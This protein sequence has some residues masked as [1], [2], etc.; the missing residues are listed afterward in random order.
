MTEREAIENHLFYQEPDPRRNVYYFSSLIGAIRDA[1][2][3]TGRNL[4]TGEKI[5]GKP[6]G[7]WLGALGY[8]TVLDQVGTCFK[9]KKAPVDKLRGV[10]AALTRFSNLEETVV[11]ALYALRCS[12]AHDFSLFNFNKKKAS[13]CHRFT[14]VADPAYPLIV[15]PETCWDGD[16]YDDRPAVF[17]LVNLLAFGDVVEAIY[18]RLL[19]LAEMNDLDIIL[20]DGARELLAKYSHALVQ[21]SNLLKDSDTKNEP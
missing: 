15:L 21:I 10:T 14:L 7:S 9:E 5:I 3:A 11:D 18:A 20:K 13:L 2:E 6:H 17:T 4:K 8:F 1:R 16:S 19:E 12:F